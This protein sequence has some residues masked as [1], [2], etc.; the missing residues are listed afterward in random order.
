MVSGRIASSSNAPERAE[1][2]LTR[3]LPRSR[4]FVDR[5]PVGLGFGCIASN[6]VVEAW[7]CRRTTRCQL[8]IALRANEDETRRVGRRNFTTSRPQ[9]RA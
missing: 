3:M 4:D 6:F 1:R 8:G 7:G 9:N 5:R 2:C